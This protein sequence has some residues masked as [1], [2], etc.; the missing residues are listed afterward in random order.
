MLSLAAA[1]SAPLRTMSQKV[2]PGAWWVTRATVMR[3]V[4]ALPADASAPPS[5][6]FL[7]PEPLEQPARVRAAAAATATNGAILRERV[8]EERSIFA[9]TS[10]CYTGEGAGVR[11][12]GPEPQ[13]GRASRRERA[14]V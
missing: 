2:S 8:C 13:I 10:L 14:K 7:P 6:D 11:G 1:A 3:G 5:S 4:E 12:S 9:C